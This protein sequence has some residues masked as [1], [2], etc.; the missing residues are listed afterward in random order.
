MVTIRITV[1]VLGRK[2]GLGTREHE[3]V[4]VALI[5][6]LK[7]RFDPASATSRLWSGVSTS[8]PPG[9][10]GNRLLALCLNHSDIIQQL[11]HHVLIPP[12]SSQYTRLT[13]QKGAQWHHGRVL[14]SQT[15]CNKTPYCLTLVKT[16]PSIL[17]PSSPTGSQRNLAWVA[18]ISQSLCSS[19]KYHLLK[20]DTVRHFARC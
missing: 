7:A 9:F 12:A 10:K 17:Y 3:E 14:R 18:S 19:F 1:Y 6:N 15:K 2:G 4:K 20:T 16:G 5:M 8:L 11:C 13:F